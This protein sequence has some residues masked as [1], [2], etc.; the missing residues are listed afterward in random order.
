MCAVNQRCPQH[1]GL[2]EEVEVGWAAQPQ[3]V[4]P[5]HSWCKSVCVCVYN[6]FGVGVKLSDETKFI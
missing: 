1:L 2:A 3:K 6:G 4:C 5:V